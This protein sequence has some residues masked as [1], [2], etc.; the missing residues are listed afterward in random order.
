MTLNEKIAESKRF[1][2]AGENATFPPETIAI[3]M[4]MSLSWLQNKRSSGGGI[5]FTKPSG[6]KIIFYKKSDVLEY[7][8]KNKLAHTA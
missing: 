3:V 6:N 2:E 7:I 8:S 1:W 4:G 5:P